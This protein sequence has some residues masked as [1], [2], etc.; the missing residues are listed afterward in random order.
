LPV[1]AISFPLRYSHSSLEICNLSDI[2]ATAK[3]LEL[4]VH[5]PWNFS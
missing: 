3:L 5:Q 4:A 2:E 1:A